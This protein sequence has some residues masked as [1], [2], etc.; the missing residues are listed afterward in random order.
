M[1]L[2]MMIFVIVMIQT[3]LAPWMK[4]IVA[5]EVLGVSDA[6]ALGRAEAGQGKMCLN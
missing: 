3:M 4:L 1:T 2:T 5:V 6:A